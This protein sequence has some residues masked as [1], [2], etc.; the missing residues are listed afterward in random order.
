M[1]SDP[2][3]F[4]GPLET[5]VIVAALDIGFKLFAQCLKSFVWYRNI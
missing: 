3:I 4:Q 1:D 5:R 2:N